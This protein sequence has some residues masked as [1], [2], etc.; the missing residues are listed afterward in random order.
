MSPPFTPDLNSRV[1][2]RED[3]PWKVLDDIILIL[4]L[5]E[6]DFFELDEV[7]GRIWKGLDGVQ[8][9]EDQAQALVD[10]YG[11]DIETARSDVIAF[12]S[13][14]YAKGLVVFAA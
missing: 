3:V 13:D 6:G 7:G 11:I 4:D 14:L 1:Q 8:M 10:E 9:I 12:V 2:R 5:K